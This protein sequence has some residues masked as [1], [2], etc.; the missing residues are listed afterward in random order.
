VQPTTSSNTG[1]SGNPQTTSTATTGNPKRKFQDLSLDDIQNDKNKKRH[2]RS[3]KTK[4]AKL[5]NKIR[6]WSR[7]DLEAAKELPTGTTGVPTRPGIKLTGTEADPGTVIKPHLQKQTKDF[8]TGTLTTH[9]AGTPVAVCDLADKA[10]KSGSDEYVDYILDQKTGRSEYSTG[11][12]VGKHKGRDKGSLPTYLGG[13]QKGDHKGHG[14]PE[15]GV[16]DPELVNV[17]PNIVPQDGTTNVSHKKVFENQVIDYAEKNKGKTIHT[18]HERFYSK[19][20]MRPL[21]ETHYMVVDGT[22]VA[23]VTIDNP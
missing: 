5:N 16:K 14:I 18:I 23:A 17:L 11:R 9:L 21:A 20:Q 2:K 12:I 19:D 8:E 3:L 1:T 13:N 6:V 22:V 10:Q 15:G 4:T 7:P